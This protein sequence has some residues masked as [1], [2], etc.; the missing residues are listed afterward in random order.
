M[1]FVRHIDPARLSPGDIALYEFLVDCARH[2][3]PAPPLYILA[4]K[5]GYKSSAVVSAHLRLLEKAGFV[6]LH[7]NKSRITQVEICASA[8]RVDVL[9]HGGAGA[10]N[11]RK[12]KKKSRKVSRATSPECPRGTKAIGISMIELTKRSCR[13]PVGEDDEDAREFLFCGCDTMEGKPWCADHYRICVRGKA[14]ED[15]DDDAEEV[16]ADEQ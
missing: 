10:V 11:M 3:K 1:G 5:I 13:Y 9:Q 12:S 7:R 4:E 15:G 8:R 14:E 16:Y 6:A 2:L